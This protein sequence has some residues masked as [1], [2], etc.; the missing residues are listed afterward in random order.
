MSQINDGGPAF[1]RSDAG[2]STTQDGMSLRVWL[3][4][5]SPITDEMVNCALGAPAGIDLSDDRE[6]AAFFDLYAAFQFEYAD[7]MLRA[8]ARQKDGQ[9]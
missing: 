4:A 9:P 8:A 7:A 1:P 6:R 2:Y 3:A 5:N